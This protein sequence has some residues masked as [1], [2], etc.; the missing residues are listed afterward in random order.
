MVTDTE[1]VDE[2]PP[3]PEMFG[4]PIEWIAIEGV[5]SMWL[6][7][8]RAVI[9]DDAGGATQHSWWAHRSPNGRNDLG[10]IAFRPGGHVLEAAEPLTIIGSLYCVPAEHCGVHG[11]IR[12]GRWVPA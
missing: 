6:S 7:K 4:E 2:W 12:D 5:E 3:G 10:R 8:P 11:W 1:R 9:D